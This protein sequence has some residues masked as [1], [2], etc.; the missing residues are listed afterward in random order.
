VS[1]RKKITENRSTVIFVVL[2]LL[3]FGSMV[4]G[5][6]G[7]RLGEG[8][9]TVVGIVVMPFLTAM[10]EVEN[11]VGYVKGLLVD[12]S[13]W[14]DTVQTLNSDFTAQ[15]HSIARLEELEAENT[16]LRSMMDFLRSQNAYEL[17]AAEVIQHS[18]GVLTLDRGSIH[19]VRESMCVITA[20]GIIGLV[21]HTGPL[22][23]NVITL[24]NANC[25]VDAMI[26]WNR[27]RGQVQGTGNVLSTICT[28]HY[29][30]LND[31]V[32]PGDVVVT[33]PDSVFPSGYPV[34]K[35]VSRATSG[36]LSQSANIQ[37]Y[38]NPF[39]VDEVFVLLNADPSQA[40]LSGYTLDNIELDN[41]PT[42]NTLSVQER[43][44]P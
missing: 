1:L 4:S 43:Y 34:G 10:N 19:G 5:A 7:G 11:G 2:V 40:D 23:S 25:K 9:K 21:T 17:M 32:R 3:S 33:S 28:M 6:S 44:A 29:I 16:R 36:Q 8:V 39:V 38:A 12:Y 22:T 24:Q 20:D 14:R 15:K 27:V 35:I 42:I 13:E 18:R 30:D 37:P 41:E 26:K 31:D